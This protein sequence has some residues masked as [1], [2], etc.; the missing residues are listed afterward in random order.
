MVVRSPLA[1]RSVFASALRRALFCLVVLLL[2][3]HH[4]FA[5]SVLVVVPHPDDE[6]LFAAGII[7]SA[8][9]LCGGLMGCVFRF[10]GEL[11][12]FVTGHNLSPEG[13]AEYRRAYPR[14]PSR[15]SPLASRIVHKY[16]EPEPITR[17]TMAGDMPM[18]A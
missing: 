15:Y 10:D 7:R 5:K 2:P 3:A 13:L 8:V 4:A 18:A 11:I 17:A 16:C 6:A 9:V 12:H 14:P 1:S